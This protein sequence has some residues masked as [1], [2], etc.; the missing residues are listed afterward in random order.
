MQSN[1]NQID[2]QIRPF[3]EP[4]NSNLL[5]LLKALFAW[6]IS[7]NWAFRLLPVALGFIFYNYIDS[8]AILTIL[9]IQTGTEILNAFNMFLYN[10]NMTL[11]QFNYLKHNFKTLFGLHES[12]PEARRPDFD[13]GSSNTNK[14]ANA[15]KAANAGVFLQEKINRQLAP[16]GERLIDTP[17]KEDKTEAPVQPYKVEFSRRH[18]GTLLFW[19]DEKECPR[20]FISNSLSAANSRNRSRP[21]DTSYRNIIYFGAALKRIDEIIADREKNNLD[22]ATFEVTNKD[23]K[24]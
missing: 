14:V 23:L 6:Y 4:E 7:Q 1:K 11:I 15:N 2:P 10:S 13:F 5:A 22:R 19:V 17:Q 24:D 9:Y 12:P 16:M 3:S 8:W 18:E 20:A 21:N